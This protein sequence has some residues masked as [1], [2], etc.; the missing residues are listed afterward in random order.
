MR[1]NP[2]SYMNSVQTVNNLS[3]HSGFVG[4]SPDH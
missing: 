4:N 2:D 3:N 1:W